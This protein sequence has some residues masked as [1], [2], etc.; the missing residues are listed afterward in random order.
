MNLT[1]ETVSL[2]MISVLGIYLMQKIQYDY[3]LVTIFKNYPL[4]TTVKNGGI[5]DIDKLYIFVQNFKYSVNAK[6]SVSVAVEGNVIK[7]LSGPG[8]IEIVFEAWGYLDRYRIQRVIKV[9]E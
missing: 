7:V 5:I 1:L 4:P 3:K 6:G 2:L 9:V 8:E